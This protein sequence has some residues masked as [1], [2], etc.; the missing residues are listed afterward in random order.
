[1]KKYTSSPDTACLSSH[2]FFLSLL[3]SLPPSLPPSPPLPSLLPFLPPSLPSLFTSECEGTDTFDF[4]DLLDYNDYEYSDWAE[5]R[6]AVLGCRDGRFGTI[7]PEGWGVREASV[8]C[9][10][11]GYSPHGELHRARLCALMCV[12]RL[13]DNW[14][15]TI[16]THTVCH[17]LA[18]SV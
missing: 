9:R 18:R 7:C 12:S 14:I 16:C 6:G 3:P 2:I 5:R 4:Y 13:F 15:W 11:F 8:A 10:E 1:M 17:L